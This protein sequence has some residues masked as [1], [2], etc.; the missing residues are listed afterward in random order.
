[1]ACIKDFN[2][3]VSLCAT[4]Y[5]HESIILYKTIQSIRFKPRQL[6]R[7]NLLLMV[8]TLTTYSFSVLRSTCG[9]SGQVYDFYLRL[10]MSPFL[11]IMLELYGDGSFI[12]VLDDYDS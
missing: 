3:V 7:P 1:M 5:Q 4:P 6:M 11:R 10:E 2:A 12:C 9:D 8:I